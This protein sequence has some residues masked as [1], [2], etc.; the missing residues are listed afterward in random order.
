MPEK[1]G[2]SRA[3][4]SEAPSHL[5]NRHGFAGC[6][7]TIKSRK[8]KLMP[9]Y[10]LFTNDIGK[11]IA[12]AIFAITFGMVLWRK[13]NIALVTLSASALIILL[14][15]A[16]PLTAILTYINW[17]VLAL[18]MG[19]GLLAGT[20]KDSG[21]PA[22]IVNRALVLV[23]KEK[24]AILF[25]CAM[26]M[27]LSCFMENPIVVIILA[28]IAIEMAEK[29]KGSLFL[30]LIAVAICANVVTTVTMISDTPT[31]ILATTTGM[32]FLDF[33]WFM[34][35]PGLGTIT[36]AGLLVA[37]LTLVWQ[38]RHHNATV[39]IK[40]E[41]IKV[42]YTPVILF[43]LSVIALAVI[44]WSSL[45]AW[46]HPGLVGIALAL[47]AFIAWPDNI[48]SM[49]FE[50]DWQTIMYLSGIFIVV[51]TVNDSG[52]L[53]EFAVWLG[54]SGIN[55]P[56]I[57]IAIFVWVSVALSSFIDN[58][59]YTV[60]M[61]PVC[62][63]V[64]R[65]LGVSPFPFYFAML[66]GTG[67]GGNLTPI[68]ATANVLACGMLEKRGYKIDFKKYFL[69]AAPFSLAAVLAVH[70]LLQLTWL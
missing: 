19:Y 23:K 25:L 64:A 61:I 65:T 58:V 69:I 27:I 45:G 22:F 34:G 37:F 36:I 49:L 59:P 38:F 21:V 12:L 44:P 63:S 7:S 62:A 33:Y 1:T 18:Y 8:V 4:K 9:W 43:V 51:S 14:G 39:E 57:Y 70:I 60:I 2:I 55:N 15:L 17:D 28:P 66:I 56:A 67:I 46:N 53:N 29:L 3:V 42:S 10:H 50:F 24:Y 47:S 32:N 68:G 52:I 41:E 30:Y 13:L 16:N 40:K 20:F 6:A 26:S 31:L 35:H 48:R 54:N 5:D 11:W